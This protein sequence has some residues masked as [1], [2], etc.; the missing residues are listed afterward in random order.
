MSGDE[1]KKV[2]EGASAEE[3]LTELNKD[4]DEV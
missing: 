2:M 3:L 1:F 4:A